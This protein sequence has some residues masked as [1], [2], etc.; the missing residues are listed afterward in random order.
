LVREVVARESADADVVLSVPAGLTA[1]TDPALLG[2]AIG[3]L[4]RNAAIHAGPHPKVEIHAAETADAVS[5]TVSD[6]GPGV[7]AEELPRIFEPFYRVDRSRSRDTGGSGLGLAIV[8]SAIET[9][10]GEAIASL[11]E[12]GGLCVTLRIPQHP[13]SPA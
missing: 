12:T 1:R 6:D 7:P 3:N 11:S 4:I 9:C 8:R 2:R 5:I 13:P 10:G